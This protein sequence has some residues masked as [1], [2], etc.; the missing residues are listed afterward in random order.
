MC[1]KREK[2][3]TKQAGHSQR[4]DL[5]AFSDVK[6]SENSTVVLKDQATQKYMGKKELETNEKEE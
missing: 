1:L 3:K 2:L 4:G 5:Q 6:L